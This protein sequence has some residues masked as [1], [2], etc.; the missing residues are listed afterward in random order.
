MTDEATPSEAEVVVVGAGPGGYVAAIRAAQ[1][2][3]DTVLVEKEALGGVCLNHGCIP[4]KA[5]IDVGES[6]HD[7]ANMED[8]GVY[9]DVSVAFGELVDWKESVVDRLTSGVGQLCEANGVTVVEGTAAFVDDGVL[10]VSPPELTGDSQTI[11]YEHAILA[12]G[13]RPI[14][15]PGFDYD[16]D[17]VLDSR[18]ALALDDQ[19]DRLVVVGAGY[20]GME[21][22]TAFAKLGTDVTVV[23]MLDAPLPG[24]DDEAT[25]LVQGR[26]E[27]LGIEFNFGEAASEWYRDIAGDVVVTAEDGD[28]DESEY[29][30]D[31]VLVAVGREP[32]TDTLDLGAVGLEPDENGFLATDEYGETDAEGVYAVGDVAGE[33]ML[34]HEASHQGTL[35]AD[36]LAGSDSRID[37]HAVPAVVFT[38]P[39]IA[40]VGLT[41]GEAADAD[42]EVSVGEMA[43]RGNGR[44]LT[45]GD[46]EGFVRVVVDESSGRVLGGEVVGPEASELIAELGV[47]VAA[48]LDASDL[49]ETVH[50]HPTLSEAVMEAAANAEGAAIHTVN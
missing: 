22:S 9:A 45:T 36:H 43:F 21:L 16:D 23:E 33:P 27:D 7:V 13:S 31:A 8:R 12:T 41:P 48:E 32:V 37:A 35:V 14:Q 5:F 50:A 34:A 42:R 39:E 49:A 28:G 3:L 18:Q 2:G 15:V 44:A 47:A 19:P 4:S 20:I 29:R 1:H 6:A 46:A 17:P 26:A 30:A 24:Y 11:E 38:D 25:E 40:T 10:E